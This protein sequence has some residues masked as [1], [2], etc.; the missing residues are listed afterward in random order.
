MI[1]RLLRLARRPNGVVVNEVGVMV[2]VFRSRRAAQRWLDRVQIQD[3][4][5]VNPRV[6]QWKAVQWP[7][8]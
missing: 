6:K 2:H 3:G 8:S 4:M 7:T 1:G 5:T